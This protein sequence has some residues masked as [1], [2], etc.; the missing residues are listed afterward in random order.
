[1]K[2]KEIASGSM[3]KPML[4]NHVWLMNANHTFVKQLTNGGMAINF[5]QQ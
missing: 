3:E 4:E 1:M 5:N 2:G